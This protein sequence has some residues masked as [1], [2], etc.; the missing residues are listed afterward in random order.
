MTSLF[1]IRL[2][3]HINSNINSQLQITLPNANQCI[4]VLKSLV[5]LFNNQAYK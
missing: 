3:M 4:Y 2:N 5:E 1:P